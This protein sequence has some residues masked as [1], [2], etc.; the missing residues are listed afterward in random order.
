VGGGERAIAGEVTVG[1]DF[2]TVVA[3]LPSAGGVLVVDVHGVRCGS[4]GVGGGGSGRRPGDLSGRV[5]RF[6]L[7]PEGVNMLL[8]LLSA[9]VEIVDI[10]YPG[11]PGVVGGQEGFG[12]VNGIDDPRV[13]IVF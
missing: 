5:D 3:L 10:D 6:G 4:G 13:D 1:G 12:M 9:A 8:P 2:A 7:G 11:F